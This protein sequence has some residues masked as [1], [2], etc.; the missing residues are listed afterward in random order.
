MLPSG[1]LRQAAVVWLISARL[2]IYLLSVHEGRNS[3][4]ISSDILLQYI[5][6][7]SLISRKRQLACHGNPH[8]PVL[9][10]LISISGKIRTDQPIQPSPLVKS[11]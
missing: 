5:L 11:T 7:Y 10:I 4:P 8:N 2:A 9:S 6:I 1:R 3:N